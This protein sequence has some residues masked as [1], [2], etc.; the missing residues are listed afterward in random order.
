M[1]FVVCIYFSVEEPSKENAHYES[2]PGQSCVF[3]ERCCCCF[4]FKGYTHISGKERSEDEIVF[5]KVLCVYVE[6]VTPV[7][8]WNDVT[9]KTN[10]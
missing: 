9:S 5:F 1:L 8:P 7:C 10:F 3:V 4:F 6:K 2:A